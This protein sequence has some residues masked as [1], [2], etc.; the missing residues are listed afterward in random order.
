MGM[1]LRMKVIPSIPRA[2]HM[3]MWLRN[4]PISSP[5]RMHCDV[6]YSYVKGTD[7]ISWDLND[8]AAT[9]IDELMICTIASPQRIELETQENDLRMMTLRTV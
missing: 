4:F 9:S 6:N 3:P 2:S 7:N 8:F 5:S 1:V